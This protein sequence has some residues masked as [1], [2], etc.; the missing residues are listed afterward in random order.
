MAVSIRYSGQTVPVRFDRAAPEDEPA[1]HDA[2]D[3]A[4]VRKY[5]AGSD[6][7]AATD[8]A[9]ATAVR[10]MPLADETQPSRETP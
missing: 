7:I 9:R 4:H 10:I 8:Q 6:G 3:R 5:G 2:G 1:I